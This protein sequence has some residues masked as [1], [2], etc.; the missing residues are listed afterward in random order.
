MNL[1][2]IMSEVKIKLPSGLTDMISAEEIISLLTGKALSKSEYYLTK[3]LEMEQEY[4]MNIAD[5][6]KRVQESDQ[7]VFS[8]WDDLIVWE[9]YQL[10]YEE[11]AEKYRNL[12]NCMT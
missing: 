7:E 3:C 6:R 11:W 9:G 4:G 5:F 1:N 2:T 8:E 10:A 12:K